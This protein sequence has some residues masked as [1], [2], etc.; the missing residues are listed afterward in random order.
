V[1][2]VAADG[3][4]KIITVA[5]EGEGRTKITIATIGAGPAR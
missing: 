1:L 2:Q 5:A 4:R 3:A